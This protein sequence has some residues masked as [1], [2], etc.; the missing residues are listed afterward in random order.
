VDYEFHNNIAFVQIELRLEEEDVEEVQGLSQIWPTLQALDSPNMWISDTGATKH[1]M[2]HKQGGINSRPSTSRTR[3]IYCQ[4][5][6]P[7]K[8]VLCPRK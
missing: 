4:A 2:K 3:G 5:V 7:R 6:K 8:E 1:S